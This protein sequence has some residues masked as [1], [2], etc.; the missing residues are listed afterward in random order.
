MYFPKTSTE[1][2]LLSLAKNWKRAFS[3]DLARSLV[4]YFKISGF[5]YSRGKNPIQTNLASKLD[6][7]LC[8]LGSRNFSLFRLVEASPKRGK[9]S[10]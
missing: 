9:R 3:V 8:I 6:I 5:C 4:V 2:P 1:I 7:N 10:T